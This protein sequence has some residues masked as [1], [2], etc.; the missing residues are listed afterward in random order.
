MAIEIGE[1]VVW[2]QQ[3]DIIIVIIV[4]G[5]DLTLIRIIFSLP[6]KSNQDD[7][8]DESRT[9]VRRMPELRCWEG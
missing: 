9:I 4:H 1:L 5:T 3:K 8:K 2:H 7:D 6:F